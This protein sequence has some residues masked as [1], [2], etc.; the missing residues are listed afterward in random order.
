MLR[1]AWALEGKRVML[2]ASPFPLTSVP[3]LRSHLCVAL[4]SDTVKSKKMIPS[5][6]D[7][8]KRP[9]VRQL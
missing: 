6:V 7:Y 2:S 5:Q 8:F 4:S 9:A 1:Y 3:A